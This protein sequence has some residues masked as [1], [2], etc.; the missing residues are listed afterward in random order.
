M[1]LIVDILDDYFPPNSGVSVPLKESISILFDREM[2]EDA[3]EEEFFIEG[4]DTDQY[5]GPGFQLLEYPDNFSQNPDGDF[6]NSPGYAGIIDGTFVFKKID[7]SNA[8]LEVAAAPYRTKMVF[9]P[10][11]PMAPQTLY[12][13]HLPEA[14]D[15]LENVHSGHYIFSWT[16][17]TGS[18]EYVPDS[19]STSV[20]VPGSLSL[21][22]A[23]TGSQAAGA[24]D[25][26][27][28]ATTPRDH[29]IQVDPETNEISITFNRNLDSA[30]VT[31]DTVTVETVMVTD[32]PKA[33]GEADGELIK[34]LEVSGNK[35]TIRI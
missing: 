31:Q 15:Y 23:T 16:T 17:G 9:T 18:I 5:V 11:E 7:M 21:P 28:V 29:A 6:L 2:D 24:G 33:T 32:H 26:E 19:F 27:V 34:T 3:I 13:A 25:L 30:S 4:P 12:T 20:L 8:D 14:I 10:S 22:V 1:A 35:L